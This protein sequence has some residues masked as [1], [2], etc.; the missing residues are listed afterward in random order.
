MKR[1]RLAHAIRDGSNSDLTTQPGKATEPST[2]VCSLCP[3]KAYNPGGAN[4]GEWVFRKVLSSRVT[5]SHVF[6]LGNYYSRIGDAI[7]NN[8][9][10][11]TRNSNQ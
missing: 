1:W 5:Q 11:I 8:N 6:R 10:L 9:P 3:Y 2:R 7:I 4:D